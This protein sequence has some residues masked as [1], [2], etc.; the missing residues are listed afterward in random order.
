M[1][2]IKIN[3]AC[4]EKEKERPHP[5]RPKMATKEMK[6]KKSSSF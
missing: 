5:K 1:K 3:L 6:K 2:K 4:R